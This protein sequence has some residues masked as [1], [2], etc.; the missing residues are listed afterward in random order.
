M[1]YSVGFP[2]AATCDAKLLILGSLPGQRS[3]ERQQ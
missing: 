2:P 3:L 1:T